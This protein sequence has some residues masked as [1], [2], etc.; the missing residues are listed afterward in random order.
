MQ[1]GRQRL[2]RLAALFLT[3]S[4]ICPITPQL[5]CAAPAAPSPGFGFSQYG[6]DIRLSPDELGRELDAVS[7]TSASWLRVTFDSFRIEH[8]KGSFDWTYLDSVVNAAR[9]RSLKVLVVLAYSPD[10]AKP[11]HSSF[12]APPTNDDDFGDFAA[13]A[14]THYRDR[15]ANWEIWNEPNEQRFFAYDGDPVAKYTSLLKTAYAAIKRV[16]PDATVITGGLSRSGQISP[17]EFIER[18]YAA[19]AKDYFDAAAMH[20]Y[21]SPGGLAADPYN[22][23]SDTA[24]VHTIMS[25]HGDS[26]KRIWMTELGAPTFRG[27]GGVSQDEQA[28]QITDVLAAAAAT[29]YSG[30]A[31]IF[32]IRDIG[33]RASDPEYSYGALL[34]ADWQ[35]KAAAAV[36]AR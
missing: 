12:S 17:P 26:A 20:P 11:A 9:S 28:K 24:R 29:D 6:G 2:P 33:T 14:A 22:G 13:A 7:R 15:V 16:Q 23:W 4:L 35:P 25:M 1:F 30:P 3:F 21:V 34:T 10:W 18:M 36:L 8:R 32:T 19:G 27:P 31:F 5:A